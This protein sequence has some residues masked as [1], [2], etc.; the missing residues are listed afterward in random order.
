MK[1]SI[2]FLLLIMFKFSVSAQYEGIKFNHELTLADALSK[3]K[4]ENKYVFVDCYTTWCGPCKLMVFD[5]FSQKQVGDY[6][7]RNFINLKLD[8]EKPDNKFIVEKYGITAFP[9]YLFFDPNGKLKLKAKAYLEA[10]IFLEMGKAALDNA[11]NFEVNAK[12]IEDGDRSIRTVKRFFVQNYNYKKSES[13]VEECFKILSDEEKISQ[14]GWDLFNLYIKDPKSES[15][16][17]FLKNRLKFT[18]KYGKEAVERRILYGLF[19]YTYEMDIAGFDSLRS[20]DPVI[21]DKAKNFIAIAAAYWECVRNKNIDNQA[22]WKNLISIASPYLE[23]QCDDSNYIG[24]QAWK[25][26]QNSSKIKDKTILDKACEWA[27]RAYTLQPKS[28]EIMNTYAHLLFATG[29]KNNA[30][31]LEEEALKKAEEAAIDDLVKSYKEE[32]HKFKQ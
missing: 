3:A 2:L 11:N 31:K 22:D 20:I 4:D 25:I 29:K 18:E 14:D 8:L 19:L 16:Q 23:D 24:S 26:Y 30:I 27:K 5:V 32:L 10:P 13:L 15:F 1:K 9:T 6:Y 21:F 28:S 17:F 12:K 7:N